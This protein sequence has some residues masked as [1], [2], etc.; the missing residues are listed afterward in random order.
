MSAIASQ[1]TN[2]INVYSA[3]YSGGDQRHSSSALLAFVLQGIDDFMMKC[4]R[5][6][7]YRLYVYLAT[8]EQNK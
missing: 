2:L 4:P 3:V 5:S 1:I 8:R 7:S 6:V